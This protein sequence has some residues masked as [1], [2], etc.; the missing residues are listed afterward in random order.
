MSFIMYL[1]E[2][3][4]TYVF[5]FIAF[6]FT[7]SVYKLDQSLFLHPSNEAYI[8]LGLAVFFIFFTILDYFILI[9]RI[10][11][12][13]NM[14]FPA[15]GEEDYE[16]LAYPLDK[17]YGKKVNELKLNLEELKGEIHTKSAE[18]ADFITSW[19]HD[20]KV[21]IAA[22][23][24][25]MESNEE[26][27]PMDLYNSLLKELNKI[28]ESAQRV[29][30]SLKINRF[31]DDYRIAPVST[32]TLISNGLSDYSS[33]FIYKGL[34][35]SMKGM[36]HDVLTDEKW[37]SYIISEIISNAVKYTAHGGEIQITTEKK[38]N[39]TIV[40]IRN[41]GEG[42]TEID[43]AQIFN[44]GFT[45]SER[46]HGNKA[47]GYGLYLAKKMSDKLGHS[48]TLQSNPQEYV[49]FQLVFHSNKTVFD[50][51]KV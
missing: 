50:M 23:K 48:L 14:S 49:E 33:F 11:R 28:E 13:Q 43:K 9:A 2:K 15:S 3:W 36:P 24:L 4:L 35:L 40:S 20:I 31:Y 44:K 42:I 1:K 17:I 19:L 34:R 7:L 18:E 26:K 29:F 16:N 47:T 32:K 46:R 30:Y 45:S 12:F 21:P 39:Q 27:I 8:L 10:K 38:G 37:S 6:I 5:I 51:T 25:I 41:E 22:G